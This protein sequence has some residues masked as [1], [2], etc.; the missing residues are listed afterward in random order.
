M[1]I[2]EGD[3]AEDILNNLKKHTSL[4]LDVDSLAKIERVVKHHTGEV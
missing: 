2:Y 4:E 3:K 1:K